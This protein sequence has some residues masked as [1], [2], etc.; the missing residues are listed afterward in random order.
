MADEFPILT[1]E[2][3]NCDAYFDAIDDVDVRLALPGLERNFWRIS[4]L[5]LPRGINIQ[6]CWSGSGDHPNF[7]LRFEA[8]IL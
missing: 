2:F 3:R 7:G 1:S 8:L 6:Y 4:S 5:S